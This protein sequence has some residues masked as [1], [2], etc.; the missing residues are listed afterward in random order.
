MWQIRPTLPEDVPGILALVGAIYT[1]YDCVFNP[2][3]DDPF[4]LD[5]GPYFRTTGGEFWV[6][7]PAATPV[8][9]ETTIDGRTYIGDALQAPDSS[10]I[11]ATGAVKLHPDAGELKTLYVHPSARRQ[12]LGRTLTEMAIAHARR[13]GRPRF[14]L[15]TDTRFHDAHRLYRGMGFVQFGERDLGDSNNSREYGFELAARVANPPGTP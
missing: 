11:L 3:L 2:E 14:F 10:P 5:P 7:I 6:A 8:R 4:L 1:E 15:W 12:G 13:A 9:A